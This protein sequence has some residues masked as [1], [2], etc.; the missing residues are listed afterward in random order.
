MYTYTYFILWLVDPL[1]DNDSET[2]N[3]T[4]AIAMQQLGKYTTVLEPLLRSGLHITLEVQ[5]GA[6]FS[7]W[8][9]PRL[10]HSTD[11]VKVVS[12]KLGC[13]QGYDRSSD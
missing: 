1:L 11:R 3:Q 2:N 4:M 12:F 7:M 13:N 8:S 6:V 9:A 10:H 5:L